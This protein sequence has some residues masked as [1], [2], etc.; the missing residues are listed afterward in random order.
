MR[1]ADTAAKI[2]RSRYTLAVASGGRKW[3]R[4]SRPRAQTGIA[5]DLPAADPGEP[6]P[7]E[8]IRAP[9]IQ[10]GL[11]FTPRDNFGI[12]VIWGHNINGNNGHWGTLGLTVRF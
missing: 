4:T 3:M 1:T 10:L 9:R 2:L 11:R 7:P 6:P 8:A 12:D 5:G